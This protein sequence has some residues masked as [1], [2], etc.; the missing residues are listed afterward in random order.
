MRLRE[1]EKT[2]STING[3]EDMYAVYMYRGVH[4]NADARYGRCS[5]FVWSNF[6]CTTRF[7][8]GGPTQYLR[9]LVCGLLRI[10]VLCAASSWYRAL[11]LQLHPRFS[12]RQNHLKLTW[13]FTFFS[14]ERVTR[15]TFVKF[16]LWVNDGA[17]ACLPA[18]LA[19]V[20][21]S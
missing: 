20:F 17:P 5:S 14:S 6:V 8:S 11:L 13:V 1:R 21:V 12:W 15:T 3:T 4:I 7:C 10:Y 19:C 9:N 2:E 16:E 18:R